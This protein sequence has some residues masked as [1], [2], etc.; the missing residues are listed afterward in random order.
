M[1][2]QR[3]TVLGLLTAGGILVAGIA[4]AGHLGFR[5][6]LTP[7]YPLGV[8]R[9]VP[10]QAGYEVGD[11]VFVC[12]PDTPMFKMALERGYLPRGLCPS[13]TGPLIKTI[14][15]TEGQ[16]VEIGIG[17]GDGVS[18]DGEPVPNST[19]KILDAEGRAL[20]PAK[21]GVVPA[22]DAFLLSAYP[23]SFDGRYFGPLPLSGVLG[24]AHPVLTH[25]P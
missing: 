14:A 17:I 18:I 12:P 3:R 24:L 22:D 10:K 23:G 13:G 19:I 9:V 4:L 16:M 25:A 5:L 2:S 1:A 7:S 15:A 6:N 21:G 11:L 8:W 20:L